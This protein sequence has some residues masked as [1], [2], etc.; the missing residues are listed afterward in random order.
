VTSRH[1]FSLALD[2]SAL[3][4]LLFVAAALAAITPQVAL[5]PRQPALFIPPTLGTPPG[6]APQQSVAPPSA[7]AASI[8]STVLPSESAPPQ[9]LP[10]VDQPSSAP[11]IARSEPSLWTDRL[12]RV[13][14]LDGG[15]GNIKTRP[16]QPTVMTTMIAALLKSLK[17]VEPVAP[18]HLKALTAHPPKPATPQS[19]AAPASINAPRPGWTLG[20]TA[21]RPAALGGPTPLAARYA[22][23]ING[24]TV[25]HQ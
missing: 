22:P 18:A 2:R 25:G 3:P 4:P 10:N 19:H 15:A 20:G 1:L 14:A 7:S 21:P 8:S 23:S 24:A 16:K 5:W 13:D 9:S 11:T 17:R 6:A 12:P